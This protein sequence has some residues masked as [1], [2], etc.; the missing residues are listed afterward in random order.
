MVAGNGGVVQGVVKLMVV[1]V[2]RAGGWA[3]SCSAGG[4]L[5]EPIVSCLSSNSNG[6]GGR[7]AET[8]RMCVQ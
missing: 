8:K 3:V 2:E 5:V 6:N 1:A 7:Q 4:R